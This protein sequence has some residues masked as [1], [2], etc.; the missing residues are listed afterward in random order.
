MLRPGTY[1]ASNLAT[2]GAPSTA[3]VIGSP[4]PFATG[5]S[6]YVPKRYKNA[7]LT[8]SA[9]YAGRCGSTTRCAS[10]GFTK[11]ASS[12]S[13]TI[14]KNRRSARLSARTNYLAPVI[15]NK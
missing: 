8:S 4:A 7:A 13:K 9:E 15:G 1:S 12:A 2:L 11:S 14:A 6:T 5:Q 10:I 3:I